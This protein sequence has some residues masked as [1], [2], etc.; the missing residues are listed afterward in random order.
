MTQVFTGTGRHF[1]ELQAVSLEEDNL[2]EIV[3]RV[4]LQ[5]QFLGEP[6]VIIADSK[7]FSTPDIAGAKE[8]L[9]LDVLGRCVAIS[10]VI[11]QV[12]SQDSYDH[13]VLGLAAQ[14]AA[15]TPDELGRISREFLA[16]PE[17]DVLRRAWDDAGVEINDEAVEL[18]SLL[19]VT[20]KRDAGDYSE[21]INKD[22][23][24]IIAAEGFD[25]K[26]INSINW[27]SN[28]GVNVKGL[29]YQK[30]LVGGQEVFFAEQCVPLA[31]AARD[32]RESM[33]LPQESIE[34]WKA[35]GLSY[36]MDLLTPAVGSLLERI[37][38]ETE[39][40][41][42]STNWANKYYFWLRGI[43]RTFRVRVYNRDRLELGFYNTSPELVEE[44]LSS[45]RLPGVEIYTVGGYSESPFISMS[46]GMDYDTEWMRMIKSWLAGEV[47]HRQD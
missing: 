37:V 33:A 23:R 47:I 30:Y 28:S 29:K 17:N 39:K 26:T 11:G 34:P 4:K 10:L 12:R 45:F 42:F 25:R 3:Q 20:F 19:A 15:Y 13:R 21:L 22:Q 41:V 8:L 31:S 5:P 27:L 9:A 1:Q 38:S 7:S 40:V 6:L 14:A 16:T 43:R 46:S 24:V 36:Y 2:D 18:A 35:K 44:F 32:S